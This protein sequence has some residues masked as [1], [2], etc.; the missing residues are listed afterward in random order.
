[1]EDIVH[2]RYDAVAYQSGAVPDSHIAR[3]GTIGRLHVVPTAP[4]DHCRVLELGCADGMNVLPVAERFP[5][6]EFLGVDFGSAHIAAAEEARRACNLGNVRFLCAD[7]REFEPEPAAYDYV[8]AHGVYSW[9]RDE[10]KDRLLAVCARALAPAGVAYVSYNTFPVWGLLGG[11]REFL[12]TETARETQPQEQIAHARRAIAALNDSMTGQPGAYAELLRQSLSDML[13]K[14]PDHLFHDDLAAVNDPCTF[15][16]FTNHAASHGMQYLAEAHYA[17]MIF[18]H[19]PAPMRAALAGL[20]LDFTRA[21][22]FMDVMFQRWLRNSLLCRS[23]APLKRVANPEVVRECALGLRIRPV[24]G[25]VNLRSGA[26]MRMTG[27]N[28]LSLEFVEPGEKAMLAA[29]AQNAP[30]RV[31]FPIALQAANRF[32]GQVGLPFMEPSAELCGMLFR[33]FTLDALD[34]A[35]TGDGDWLRTGQPPA[36]SALMQYQ[37]RSGLL[38][39]NRWHEPV[40]ITPEGQC[41]IADPSQRPSEGALRAGLLV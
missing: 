7:L 41:Y 24:E 34:L 29:L 26:P 16:A 33:L 40:T 37:A 23:D 4:P 21:Q 27:L 3:I 2:A 15:T 31:P 20:N 35:L 19:V 10:I 17:T 38:V 28:D 9:V 8:I 30:A 1:M 13:R 11:L 5:R 18:E 12:F 32:L 39:V 14:R 36:P 22:Q 6:S 25:Q